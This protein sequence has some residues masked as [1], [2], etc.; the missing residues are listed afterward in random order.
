MRGLIGEIFDNTR[1]GLRESDIKRMNG[2]FDEGYDEA[3]NICLG[4]ITKKI[5]ELF[6]KINS[7][8]DSY[9]SKE[10]QFMLSKLKELK[11]ETEEQLRNFYVN[12]TNS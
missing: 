12:G 9:L 6:S 10:E 5:D 2:A 11:S 1:N 4:V 3:A 8:S 7:D